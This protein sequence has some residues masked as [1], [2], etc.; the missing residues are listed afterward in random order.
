MPLKLLRVDDRLVHGQVV[1]SWLPYLKVNEIWIASDEISQDETRKSIMRFA[2][3]SNV[4]LEIMTVKR[5]AER[6]NEGT[7]EGKNVMALV[8][9]LEEVVE[10]LENG[11]KINVLNIGGMHYSAGKT[12]SIGKAIFLS[13]DDA[14]CLKI[15]SGYGVKIEGK[16]LPTDEPVDLMKIIG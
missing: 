8:P 10:L 15:I 7:F 1:E 6:I 9:G 3:P 13:E 12:Q 14:A 11:V 4:S 2:T 16:G 5:V